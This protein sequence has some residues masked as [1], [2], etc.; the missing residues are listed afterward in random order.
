MSAHDDLEKLKLGQTD[1]PVET[2]LLKRWSPRCFSGQPIETA[3][4]RSIFTAAAWA[5]SSYNEQPWRFLVGQ[6]GDASW[7]TIFAALNDKNQS[8]AAAAPVLYAG[9]AKKT[10]TMTGGPNMVAVHD[11][12]AAS[13]NLSLQ[14]AALGIH[15]HGMAGFDREKL[16]TAFAIPDDFE[17]VACWAMGYLGEVDTL[18]S[19]FKEME[20]QQRSRKT[21]DEFVFSAWNT[22]ALQ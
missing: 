10:F 6:K 2:L 20:L 12:G 22:P 13:A 14:A 11:L 8:W 3:D 18:S 7:K 16:Q 4:L 19:P 1:V 9:F 15:T 5:G 21:L 17:A